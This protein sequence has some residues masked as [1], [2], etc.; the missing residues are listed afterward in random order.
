MSVSH[1]APFTIVL[2]EERTKK[3]Q[4]R[5]EAVRSVARFEIAI[6]PADFHGIRADDLPV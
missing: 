2:S 6:T 1:I 4:A 5:S 3:A